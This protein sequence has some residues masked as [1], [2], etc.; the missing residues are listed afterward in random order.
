MIMFM[1]A[2]ASQTVTDASG[3]SWTVRELSWEVK[4]YTY[5]IKHLLF[6]IM[7]SDGPDLFYLGLYS[8]VLL[9]TVSDD[10]ILCDC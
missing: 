1:L 10:I 4:W 8:D 2:K 9:S 6:K 7:N 5:F 3:I